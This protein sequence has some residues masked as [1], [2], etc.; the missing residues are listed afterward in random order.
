MKIRRTRTFIDWFDRLR[1]LRARTAIVSRIDRL[2]AGLVGDMKSVGGGVFEL[3]VHIGPGYRRYACRRGAQVVLLLCGG[4]KSSQRRNIAEAQR[5]VL[6][7]E[8]NP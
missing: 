4:D 2:S 3:R 1:D 8:D 7:L 5:M 6:T